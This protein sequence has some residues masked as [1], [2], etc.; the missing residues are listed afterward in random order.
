[1]FRGHRVR[2]IAAY[3]PYEGKLI[4]PGVGRLHARFSSLKLLIY[5]CTHMLGAVDTFLRAVPEPCLRAASESDGRRNQ[6]RC[7]SD[8]FDWINND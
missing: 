6:S 8:I 4:L 1:M 5:S 7:F 3:V 2:A